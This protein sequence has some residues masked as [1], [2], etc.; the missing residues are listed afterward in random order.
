MSR[1]SAQGT[2]LVDLQH[3]LLLPL[4]LDLLQPNGLVLL[5]CLNVSQLA[6]GHL[7]G[8][9]PTLLFCCFHLQHSTEA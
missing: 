4:L 8:V 1:T 6:L 3:L 9:I 2:N 5:L 7:A